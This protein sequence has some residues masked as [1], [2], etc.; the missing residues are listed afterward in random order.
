[1][2]KRRIVGIV[3]LAAGI[4]LIAAGVFRGELDVILRKAAVVCMECIGLG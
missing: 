3:I 2:N 1:M 4:T